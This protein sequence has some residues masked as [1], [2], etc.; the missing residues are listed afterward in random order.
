MKKAPIK[1]TTVKSGDSVISSPVES[2]YKEDNRSS[3]SI[4][5]KELPEIKDWKIGEKYKIEVTVEMTGISK[6]T[7]SEGEPISA[8]F[9]IDGHSI[10]V[11]DEKKEVDSAKK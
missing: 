1:K 4:N 2:K 7:W 9:K 11:D 8:S 10:K 5:E 6:D 3:M